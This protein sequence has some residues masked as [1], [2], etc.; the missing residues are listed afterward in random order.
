MVW[1]ADHLSLILHQEI[2]TLPTVQMLSTTVVRSTVA[3]PACASVSH[4][5]TRRAMCVS[6]RNPFDSPAEVQPFGCANGLKPGLQQ[7]A[8]AIAASMSI[9]GNSLPRPRRFPWFLLTLLTDPD[10][11]TGPRPHGAILS[12]M[13]L[14]RSTPPAPCRWKKRL[15]TTKA[16]CTPPNSPSPV[17]PPP[18]AAGE[19]GGW[20]RQASVV[21][22]PI[23]TGT[24]PAGIGEECLSS[25]PRSLF[26]SQ[27]NHHAFDVSVVRPATSF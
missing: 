26:L 20:G 5:R 12:R 14:L 2:E 1:S 17:R 16:R 19:R 7:T 23:S 3:A 10:S 21:A 6:C 25:F 24:G 18:P 9:S 27:E 22:K 8:P 4:D 11:S 15:D 13:K